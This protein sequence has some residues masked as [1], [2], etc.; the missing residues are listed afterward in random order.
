MRKGVKNLFLLIPV[1]IIGAA[2]WRLDQT[3][4]VDVAD[5]TPGEDAARSR[6]T[7]INLVQYDGGQTRWTLSAPRAQEGADGWTIVM[8]PRLTLYGAEGGVVR[9]SARSGRVAGANREMAFEQSVVVHDGDGGRLLT[10]RLRFDPKQKIL[11]NEEFFTAVREGIELQG[12]GMRLLEEGRRLEVLHD[13][14]MRLTGGARQWVESPG[15]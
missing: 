10:E 8:E 11:H 6:V 14:T 7:G 13:V 15:R 3:Q 12:R 9:V 2:L 5:P 4:T 1:A